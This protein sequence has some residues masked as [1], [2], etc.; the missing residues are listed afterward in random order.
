MPFD[1]QPQMQAQA[2]ALLSALK[3]AEVTLKEH[4]LIA[5][6]P[7]KFHCA[8]SY[9]RGGQL[10]S[11]ALI[12]EESTLNV[13]LAAAC[14]ISE[15]VTDLDVLVEESQEAYPSASSAVNNSLL[16]LAFCNGVIA[17]NVQAQ[18]RCNP[19]PKQW[20]GSCKKEVFTA[21]I[22]RALTREEAAI[23]DAIRCPQDMKH[24]LY[25]SFS[26]GKWYLNNARN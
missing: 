22:I 11:V 19:L 20:K 12:R 15:R 21:R 8:L 3:P 7:G 24:N 25:D 10:D 26:L 13:G 14:W 23:F 18:I 9:F 2:K 6:D 17:G 4:E 1:A 16:P 5:V